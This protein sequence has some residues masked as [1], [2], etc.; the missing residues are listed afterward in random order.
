MSKDDPRLRVG[1]HVLVQLGSELVTDVEQAI[2]ECV[3]N[4]YDADSP[5]CLIEIDS[6]ETNTLVEQGTAERLKRFLESTDTV[7]AELCDLNGN[8]I[9]KPAAVRDDQAVQ[10]RLHCTG[11]ITIED[12]GTGMA[13]DQLLSSWLVISQSEKRNERGGPKEKTKGGRTPLGDKGV[14]RLGSMKLGD[15]LVVESATGISKP[16]HKAQFRWADCN[17]AATVDEIPVFVTPENNSEGFKGTRVSVYGLREISEWQHKNRALDL[18]RSLAKLISPFES[19]ATFPV[20][21]VHDGMDLSLDRITNDALK[22][23]VAEFRFKWNSENKVLSA[24]ARFKKRLFMSRRST[25]LAERTDRIFGKDEG[26][27]FAEYLPTARRI[28]KVYDRKA[29]DLNATWFVDLKSKFKWSSIVPAGGV[30]IEDPGSFDGAFY[31]FHFDNSEESDANA[32]SGLAFDKDLIKGMSGITILRD[33]FRVRSQGDWLDISAGMTSGSTYNMR[34]DNTVGYFALTGEENY[35]LV[36]KSD[37]EGFVEDTAYRG[38]LQIAAFCRDFANNSLENVRRSLD[39]F[40]KTRLEHDV[41]EAAPTAE[42]SLQVVENNLRSAKQ[43]RAKAETVAAEL[44][45]EITKIEQSSNSET[46]KQATSN[47]LRIA[48]SAVKAIEGFSRQLSESVFP[49]LDLIRIKQEFEERNERALL[50]LESAAVGLSARGL[51]HELRTHLMEI[52][53]KTNAL[54]KIAN[55]KNADPQIL[56][57]V[58]DIRASCNAIIRAAGLIDPMLPRSRAAKEEID[59]RS[60]IE[61]YLET[62]RGSI[63]SNG[64]KPIVSGSARIVRAN[65]SRLIQVLDNLVRNSIY[66]LR[67]G[68]ADRPKRIQF[69]LNEDGFIIWDSGPGVNERFEDTLFDLFVTG[70]PPKDGGQGLGLFIVKQLLQIDGC[71]IELLNDRNDEGRRYKFSINLGPLVKV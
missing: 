50:L 17:V 57:G 38:F 11:R 24:E 3:K 21:I 70:R 10:R 31:F 2:L 69:R 8:S 41:A 25:K 13:A 54:E 32:A 62:R 47:A 44:Q 59:I 71:D 27:T 20:K 51:A 53:Q 37:R 46:T 28:E 68:E 43:A 12:R 7:R 64:I 14:G 42:R 60:L 30:A 5:G 66:W 16:I 33:G 61:E 19:R 6:R 52:R 36:E 67:R 23:A 56:P 1:A 35:R 4:A 34:V 9:S 22:Q 40:A 63:E 15:V 26:K 65:R 18:A 45:Q 29:V 39:D 49:E 58:R 55:R 48:N